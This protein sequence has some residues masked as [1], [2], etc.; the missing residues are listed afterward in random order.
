MCHDTSSLLYR[1]FK[2]V[3][4]VSW[5]ERPWAWRTC[6]TAMTENLG[7]DVSRLKPARTSK[8]TYLL[9]SEE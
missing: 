8:E 4:A 1:K 5:A 6:E 9:N 2:S 3:P 7:S